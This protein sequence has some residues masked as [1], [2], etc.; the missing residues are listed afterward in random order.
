MTV[1]YRE[2]KYITR[3][4]CIDTEKKIH[5]SRTFWSGSLLYG[6]INQFCTKCISKDDIIAIEED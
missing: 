5:L 6:Y 4:T 3:F 2:R 1:T